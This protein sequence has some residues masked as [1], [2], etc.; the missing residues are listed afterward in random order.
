MY[1]TDVP[2][3]LQNQLY[4]NFVLSYGYGIPIR[5]V[6]E[7]TLIKSWSIYAELPRNLA[8][9]ASIW[10]R[11]P[12]WKDDSMYSGGEV[13][14]R[15]CAMYSAVTL[16]ICNAQDAVLR[17]PPLAHYRKMLQLQNVFLYMELRGIRYDQQNV[18]RMLQETE[19]KLK[20]VGDRL[21]SEAGYDLRGTKGSLSAKKML[22]VL[23]TGK[24]YPPQFMADDNGGK[25]LT[26]NIEAILTLKRSR[27]DDTFLSDVHIATSGVEKLYRYSR[28]RRTS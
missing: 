21:T 7:D 6:A 17:G 1:R 9:Q 18:N 28:R 16:E 8:T 13:L 19:E 15:G 11:Q 2:K 4:D 23:Y 3:V 24:A 20:P 10:T 14:Y 25:K 26:T 27:P 12:L 5:A 22:Q